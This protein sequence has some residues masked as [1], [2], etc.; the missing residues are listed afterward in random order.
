MLSQVVVFPYCED[1]YSKPH[2][3]DCV[4]CVGHISQVDGEAVLLHETVQSVRL[5]NDHIIIGLPLPRGQ[6]ANIDA[7][8]GVSAVLVRR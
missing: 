7:S 1:E 4:A 3:P 2:S 8:V 5:T 6:A